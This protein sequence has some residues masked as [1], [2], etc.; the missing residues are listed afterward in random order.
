[1]PQPRSRQP[2]EHGCM[3]CFS[4]DAMNKE[5]V[6]P[7][8]IG[9][10]FWFYQPCVACNSKLGSSVDSLLT[11]HP[12]VIMRR[13]RFG[14]EGQKGAIPDL[15]THGTLDRS[16]A[17][18]P[19]VVRVR[20]TIDSASGEWRASIIPTF[21]TLVG[22]NNVKTFSGIFD[23]EVT[24]RKWFKKELAR[25]NLAPATPVECEAVW[26]SSL[27]TGTIDNP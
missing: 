21:S 13:A 11:D 17:A 1:M 14:I 2:N 7:Q 20:K 5:H 18:G 10:S 24:A 27:I 19:D 23:D 25:Q 26:Q 15:F 8:S 3:F 9:G 12:L 16:S 22:E 6:F 4:S